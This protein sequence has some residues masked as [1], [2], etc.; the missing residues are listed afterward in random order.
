M[1]FR[2]M[3][4]NYIG[5]FALTKVLQP[6]LEKSPIPSRIV[7]VSSFTH[8]NGKLYTSIFL[9]VFAFCLGYYCYKTSSSLYNTAFTK[10]SQKNIFSG[11]TVCFKL[12]FRHTYFLTKRST[13]LS[14]M[15]QNELYL[16]PRARYYYI[17]VNNMLAS[18]M[19]DPF[20]GYCMF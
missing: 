12:M 13:S 17:S 15:G 9:H 1:L 20:L 5:T 2:M 11:H 7:N 3:G 4:T 10:I 18:Q 8:W 16:I 6:L 14:N 19:I